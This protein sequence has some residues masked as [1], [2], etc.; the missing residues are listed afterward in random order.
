MRRVIPI[1]GLICT[2]ALLAGLFFP[3]GAAVDRGVDRTNPSR[4][5]F[6]DTPSKDVIVEITSEGINP[7][8]ASVTAGGTVVW[9]NNSGEPQSLVVELEAVYDTFVPVLFR[10]SGSEV[11]RSAGANGASS[12]TSALAPAS[13][14]TRGFFSVNIPVGGSYSH[15]YTIVGGFSFSLDLGNILGT[16]VVVPTGTQEISFDR[17]NGTLT[18]RVNNVSLLHILKLLREG[19]GLDVVVPN[20]QDQPVTADFQDVPV[21]IGLAQI[22]PKGTRFHYRAFGAE[23]ETNV[24]RGTTRG[25]PVV[26]PYPGNNPPKTDT[27][28]NPGDK[29]PPAE[30]N[31]DDR[32]GDKEDPELSIIVPPGEG[33]KQ[34]SEPAYELQHPRFSFLYNASGDIVPVAGAPAN[35]G[36]VQSDRLAG[37][38]IYAVMVNGN[39]DFIGSMQDPLEVAVH[40]GPGHAHLG[41]ISSQGVFNLPLPRNYLDPK[42][43]AGTEIHFYRLQEPLPANVSEPLPEVL[44]SDTFGLYQPYLTA[45]DT[46]TG[47]ELSEVLTL[48]QAP[49]RVEDHYDVTELLRSGG[50]GKKKNLVIL[51]D[52]FQAGSDQTTFNNFVDTYV[53]QG[54]FE[55]GVLRETM[56]AF[57]IFRVNLESNDSGVTQIDSNGNVT[58]SRDTALGYRYSGIWADCWMKPGPNTNSTMTSILNHAVPEWDY[59]FIILNETSGGGCRR[60][61]TAAVTI[62]NP[63]GW[64]TGNHE[65]SHM[66]G[67]LGDEYFGSGKYTGGE[68]SKVNLTKQTQRS[69]IKWNEWIDPNT[70]IPT[71]CS[72]VSDNTGDVGLFEGATI[73]TTKYDQ[74]LYRPSCTGRMR[75]N[76]QDH[77]PV[78]YTQMHDMV[79][80]FHDYTYR[81]SYVGDFNGDGRDDLVLHN[82]NS[83]ALYVSVGYELELEWIV[84]GELPGWDDFR[85]G[86]QFFVAD[87]NGDGMDDLYV[88]NPSDWV[89]PYFAMLRSNGSGFQ[90][91]RRFDLELPGWDDMR[92]RDQF[93]V[94]D[95]DRDGKD[96]LA[97]FN[98]GDWAV[99]Y[100]ELLRST[101]SDLDYVRRYDEELPGWDD[102]KLRDQFYIADFNDDGR[103]DIYVF[104]YGD[105][106]VGYLEMLASNGSSLG[107]VKRFDE[108]LPG[109]DDMRAN[110]K[111]YVADLNEDGLDDLYVFNGHDWSMGYLEMLASTGTNL[112]AVHRY[113]GSV[114]G[115]DDLMPN[116]QFFVADVNGD[117]IDDL[118]VYNATDWVT[119]YLGIL[120]STTTSLSGRWQDGW[121]NSWNLGANDQFLVANFNGGAGWEDLFVRN[122][123]WFGLLR[124]HRSSVGLNAI[125]PKWIHNHNYHKF[126]WW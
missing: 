119:E 64:A 103:D 81:N 36:L 2:A 78:G 113:D 9:Q 14:H 5:A 88:F 30:V 94:G 23:F 20:L 46:V 101:G 11:A 21:D 117:S 35:S 121:I 31:A 110:D 84:T 93:F 66:V 89:I 25:E 10:T 124:S 58:T 86:D 43:L 33:P 26:T 55:H 75:S 50:D 85:Q 18:L 42:Q 16:I 51:G 1:F 95:F 120:K 68:P 15:T 7:E 77:N 56:N 60:G 111:F 108:E 102:M 115:W 118:Y 73:G 79:D 76:S 39:L 114:P 82:Q 22:L 65:L 112:S 6:Q 123:D 44:N 24:S 19:Y 69:K 90:M 99:G 53:M 49:A 107:Y 32:S 48:P 47:S 4:L 92:W 54:V 91:V 8:L 41:L 27:P 17:N 37:S 13:S 126:G 116:D 12:Q 74:D 96:D 45:I 83:L 72:D 28:L 122:S 3:A 62:S 100:F 57:N 29:L 71:E 105:W 61:N 87:F 104:N 70:P 63:T 38:F 98:Y 67:N 80:A 52:G 106:D 34:A 125:Y 40:G 59:V 97:V 109:W